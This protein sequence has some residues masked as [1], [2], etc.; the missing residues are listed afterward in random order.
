MAVKVIYFGVELTY[1]RDG[2]TGNDD[3]LVALL[4]AVAPGVV[5]GY[6]P[7]RTNA[8]ESLKAVLGP[9]DWEITHADPEPFDP[10]VVY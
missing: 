5:A 3:R 1:T 10:K 8:E 2:W 9:D 4:N 7:E 6:L